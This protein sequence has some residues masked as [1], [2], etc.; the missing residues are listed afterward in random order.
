MNVGSG[1]WSGPPCAA[2]SSEEVS[3]GEVPSLDSISPDRFSN[4]IDS[5]LQLLG[6]GVVGWLVGLLVFL[7]GLAL[8]TSFDASPLYYSVM[9]RSFLFSYSYYLVIFVPTLLFTPWAAPSLRS[10]W[11]RIGLGGIIGLLCA[12]FWIS[13]PMV[14][15]YLYGGFISVAVGFVLMGAIYGWGISR[16]AKDERWAIS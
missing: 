4:R 3:A 15:A 1:V 16:V 2:S 5:I 7:P 6:V 8:S 14:Q 13:Q 10:R 11:G 12:L 9:R